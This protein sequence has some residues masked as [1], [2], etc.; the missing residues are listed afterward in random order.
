M[1]KFL[2]RIAVFLCFMLIAP[3]LLN[4]IPS[5]HSLTQVEAAAKAKLYTTKGTIGISSTP[6]YLYVENQKDNAKYTYTSKNK[7]VA[8]VGK[9]G[10]LTGISKGK[11]DIIVKETYKGK[12]TTVGT[13]KL[14]V[15]LSKL[16]TK[17]ID[18]TAFDHAM[19][20][21]KYFNYK[22]KYS[23][24]SA[25]KSIVTIEKG[26]L[27]GLKQGT[28]TVS[29]TETYKK[30]NRKLGSFTVNVKQPTISEMSK[31]IDIGINS[32][33][34]PLS[35]IN[36]DN[37][38]WYATTSCESADSNIVSVTTEANDWGEV[39]TVI[40]GVA[41]GTTEITVYGEYNGQKFEIGKVNV[42]VKEIPITEFK[43]DPDYVDEELGYL[44][45]T[46]YLGYDEDEYSIKNYLI[47]NPENAT[48]PITFSSSNE[49][50]AKVDNDGKVTAISKGTTM[51]TATCGSFSDKMEVVVESYDEY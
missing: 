6:E 43:F 19:A 3:T 8:T 41:L 23:L 39:S 5:V 35:V 15:A 1:S 9:T 13:Y 11:T 29:V 17:K 36:V 2:K 37:L 46:Y 4:C 50:V 34:Y 40:K 42:T 10:K 16:S 44:S 12:T 31:S 49:S 33:N 24:V 14:D 30:K 51:I 27:V 38:S 48:T 47:R 45:K 22:A 32:S 26:Y 21:I 7:K 25:D 18:I 28:T 20:P